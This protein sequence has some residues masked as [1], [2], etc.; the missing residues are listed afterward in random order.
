MTRMAT[1]STLISSRPTDVGRRSKSNGEAE[2]APLTEEFNGEQDPA[3][4]SAGSGAEGVAGEADVLRAELIAAQERLSE[5]QASA[6]EFRDRYLRSR[7][8]LENYRRRALADAERAKA[9][10]IDAAVGTVLRVFDDLQRAITM[11]DE[12]VEE[13]KLLPGVRVVL[14]N[15]EDDMQRI[16]ITRLGEAG[17]EFDPSLHEALT[18]VPATPEHP[19]GTIAQVVTVGFAEGERLIRPASVVVYND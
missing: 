19:A 16:G 3:R 6:D 11:A 8:D 5:A 10:G 12:D 7:A 2:D 1:S 18:A 17:E 9:A 15:L 14:R 4:D 13:A